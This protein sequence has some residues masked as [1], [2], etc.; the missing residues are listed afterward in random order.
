MD[1][2][3]NM[4]IKMVDLGALCL[5]L[6]GTHGASLGMNNPLDSNFPSNKITQR[7]SEGSIKRNPRPRTT[8]LTDHPVKTDHN[9]KKPQKGAGVFVTPNTSD[10]GLNNCGVVVTENISSEEEETAKQIQSP[11]LEGLYPVELHESEY[12][13]RQ[14]AIVDL[15]KQTITFTG[16]PRRINNF[17]PIQMTETPFTITKLKEKPETNGL[18]A[19]HLKDMQTTAYVMVEIIG[20][21]SKKPLTTPSLP[22]T[23]KNDQKIV[24]PQTQKQT[25]D[26]SPSSKRKVIFFIS[27]GAMSLAVIATLLY[28]ENRLPDGITQWI[29]KM[30]SSF[31]HYSRT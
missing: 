27:V 30:M 23:Q 5:L 18:Y 31:T 8:S 24:T 12:R 9:I 16:N 7:Y 2:S 25:I 29:E 21:K 11:I 4:K 1:K 14:T 3:D 13:N 20:E 26:A 15:V 10:L 28:K 6:I 22:I 17:I 19:V